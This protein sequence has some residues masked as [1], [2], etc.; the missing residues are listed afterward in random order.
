MCVRATSVRACWYG[1]I[2]STQHLVTS[3]F[4]LLISVNLVLSH[5][6]YHLTYTGTLQLLCIISIICLY[7][8]RALL[9]LTVFQYSPVDRMR[10]VPFLR[11]HVPFLERSFLQLATLHSRTDICNRFTNRRHSDLCRTGV[12]TSDVTYLKRQ[13]IL[14]IMEYKHNTPVSSCFVRLKLYI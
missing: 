11:F 5:V 4:R 1:Y 12:S 10:T 8:T 6:V 14:K 2:I 9:C 13:Y 3:Y 7:A